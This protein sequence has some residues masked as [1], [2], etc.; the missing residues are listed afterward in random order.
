MLMFYVQ[1]VVEEKIRDRE[2]FINK[3]GKIGN[4]SGQQKGSVLFVLAEVKGIAP[5][6]SSELILK[7]KVSIM[8]IIHITL[9]L[10]QHS[11]RWC[12]VTGLFHVLGVV[13]NTLVS[14]FMGRQ[15]ATSAFKMI[16]S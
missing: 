13:V 11:T 8:T 7:T 6:S 2:E 16:N 14:V 1:Q 15:V 10:K 9:E 4:E 3:K 12:E 5:S